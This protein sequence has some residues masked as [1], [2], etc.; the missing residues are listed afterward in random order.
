MNQPTM[1]DV[2]AEAGVSQAT[3]SIVLNGSSAGRV[4]PQTSQRVLEAAKRLGYRTNVHAKVLRE[5]R[6]RM[7]GLIGDEVASTEFAG[8]MILGA[9]QEAWRRGHVLLTLDT[10]GDAGLEQAALSMMQSYRVAGV[11]YASMYHRIVTPP[12]GLE[13][14]PAV[15]VNA[16]DAGGRLTSIFPDEVAGGRAAAEVL[17]KAGHRR[18]AMINIAE[19]GS[20]LPAAS[21]RQKGFTEVLN[22][23]GVTLE[24]RQ[25]RFGTGGYEDGLRFGAQL[26]DQDEAPTAIFCGNDRTALGVYHVARMR[27]VA[28]PDDLSLVGFDDQS[29]LAPMFSP[30]LTTFELPF[31]EMGRLAV[32]EVLKRRA[33]PKK[34]TVECSLK[35]R[36]SVASAKVP[37]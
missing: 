26:L 2:A 11:I 35:E 25:L 36:Q 30:R 24:S 12:D 20:R 13:G 31:V 14:V 4:S 21:G 7:I 1:N 17:L 5:G 9:Q 15:C 18:I 23:A 3:V 27:N 6:S 8:Q 29:L 16:Q 37:A 10:V 22:D 33:A 34:L 32:T 19:E 28:I